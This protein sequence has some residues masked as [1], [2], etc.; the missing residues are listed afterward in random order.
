MIETVTDAL[1]VII[2]MISTTLLNTN[3]TNHAYDN[4]V[5][6]RKAITKK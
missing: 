2:S 4:I 5:H 1:M 6:S 3:S